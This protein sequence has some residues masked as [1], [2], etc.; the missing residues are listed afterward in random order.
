MPL[1]L[2]ELT[3]WCDDADT[4]EN[5]TGFKVAL[6]TETVRELIELARQAQ[7]PKPVKRWTRKPRS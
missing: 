4:A 6:D 2:D 1:N 5:A 7:Q 3:Q